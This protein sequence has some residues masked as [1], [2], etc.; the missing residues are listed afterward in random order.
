[1]QNKE[2]VPIQSHKKVEL[3]LG[4]A[5]FQKVIVTSIQIIPTQVDDATIDIPKLFI[6]NFA[7]YRCKINECVLNIN[8]YIPD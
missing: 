5:S 2:G 3:S 7:N 6:L 4:V 1:M 8:F